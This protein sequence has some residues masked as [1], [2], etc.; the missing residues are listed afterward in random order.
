MKVNKDSIISK[1][2][3]SNLEI[4]YGI[5]YSIFCYIMWAI[6]SNAVLSITPDYVVLIAT[7]ICVIIR[8]VVS[9]NTTNKM[10]LLTVPMFSAIILLVI[11][12]F[13]ISNI[14][15]VIMIWFVILTISKKDSVKMIYGDYISYARITIYILIGLGIVLFYIRSNY[16]MHVIRCYFI[17][18]SSIIWLLREARNY[19]NKTNSKKKYLC[20]FGI[21]SFILIMSIQP[22]YIF[23]FNIIK[24][25]AVTVIKV[26]ID[27]LTVILEPIN[28]I[29]NILF[30]GL[31]NFLSK[32]ADR[33]SK[34]TL[35]RLFGSDRNKKSVHFQQYKGF[36]PAV[37]IFIKIVILVAIIVISYIIIKKYISS[38]NEIYNKKNAVNI[39]EIKEK[40]TEIKGDRKSALRILKDIFKAKDYRTQICRKYQTFLKITYKKK[41]FRP[42]MTGL[43]IINMTKN[44]PDSENIENITNIYNESKFSNHVIEKERLEKFKK[45]YSHIKIR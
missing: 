32:L 3:N 27:I 9:M 41:I 19:Y 30:D 34:K 43:D 33:T 12:H 40:I 44:M 38:K 28:K 10:M 17:Y 13:E 4:I 24:I 31:Y 22:I 1:Y 36:P 20:N 16:M 35:D 18:L 39:D 21:V 45:S 42:H 37:E 6:I 25:V 14:V 8:N 5:S 29:M 15:S 7:V 2:I 23:V 11:L 26:V